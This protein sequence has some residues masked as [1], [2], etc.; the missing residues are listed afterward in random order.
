M[1][2]IAG[3]H[4]TAN[5]ANLQDVSQAA[6]SAAQL[7]V[8]TR[9]C[10]SICTSL[11]FGT[12]VLPIN[13]I[14][15][16]LCWPRHLRTCGG[17]PLMLLAYG[18][19]SCWGPGDSFLKRRTTAVSEEK[20]LG[21]SILTKIHVFSVFT[22]GS[23]GLSSATCALVGVVSALAYFIWRMYEERRF[24]NDMVSGTF[25][26]ISGSLQA[27]RLMLTPNQ[28]RNRH[29]IGFGGISSS[30]GRSWQSSRL[31]FITSPS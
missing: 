10:V 6:F 12:R 16:I 21:H 8:I 29:T 31:T 19:G 20:G 23:I 5:P 26:R 17:L 24:Y 7:A 1:C 11:Q 27:A 25:P 4:A 13:A 15:V 30:W 22:M 14:Q 9:T 2:S 3:L 28:S 18:S